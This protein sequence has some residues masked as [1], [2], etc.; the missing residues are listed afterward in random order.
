MSACMKLYITGMFLTREVE[1]PTDCY[2]VCNKT[3]IKCRS[4]NKIES[5]EISSSIHDQ[6]ILIR[7][8]RLFN[9]IESI[10]TSDNMK[11]G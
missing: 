11:V 6:L 3:K 2:P 7:V 8:P 10:Q 1:Q 5:P 4:V 9:R